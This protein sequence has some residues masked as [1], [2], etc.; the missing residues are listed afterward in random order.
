[1]ISL[2]SGVGFTIVDDGVADLQRHVQLGAGK[3]L[4][5]IFEAVAAAG[6][7]RHVGD[8]LGGIDGDLLDAV[9]ILGEHHAALQFAGRIVE[10]HDR[11][12]RAFQ[13]LEGAGDQLR[14]ALHQHLQRD[15]VGHVALFDAPAGEV[16]IGLRG[17]GKPISISLKPMSS[18]SWNMRALR[19]WPIGSTSAW[20][21]SRRST[22]HQIGALV[23]GLRRP[24]AVRM[25]I[26]G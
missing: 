9:H 15:V 21:P 13:R 14:P 23:D 24:G 16:E 8:H 5:R 22:E 25:L 3:A 6:L 18:S 12:V 2:L 20:L 1:M 19:S 17:R 4:R 11:R 10:M 26:C 7:G